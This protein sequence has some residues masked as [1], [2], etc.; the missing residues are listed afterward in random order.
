MIVKWS[1][2]EANQ[3]EVGFDKEDMPL[4]VIDI[5][6]RKASVKLMLSTGIKSFDCNNVAEAKTETLKRLEKD[7]Q[8][9]IS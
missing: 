4:C 8:I 7:I 5:S 2:I 3:Q 9:Q 6:K 1:K